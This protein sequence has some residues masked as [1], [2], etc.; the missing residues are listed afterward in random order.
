[1]HNGKNEDPVLMYIIDNTVRETV[2]LT[3]PDVLGEIGPC[4]RI[5]DDVSDGRIDFY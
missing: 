5:A 2:Y 1:M 4:I 3:A